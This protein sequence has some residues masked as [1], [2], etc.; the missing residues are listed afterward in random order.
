MREGL[1]LSELL[2]ALLQSTMCAVKFLGLLPH[3]RE[4]IITVSEHVGSGAGMWAVCLRR[5]VLLCRLPCAGFTDMQ[6]GWL[7][8]RLLGEQPPRPMRWSH[9]CVE[10]I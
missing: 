2:L 10:A 5:H 6:Q 1:L 8:V 4:H 9:I 3:G 7:C